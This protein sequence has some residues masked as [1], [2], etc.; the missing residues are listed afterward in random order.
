LQAAI[1][2]NARKQEQLQQEI[3]VYQS[4]VQL[5]PRIEQEFKE[6]TR[7]YDTALNF[8]RDMLKKKTD[9][10][11]AADL[12][13][14][15]QGEQF[16]V[17]DSAN[18]PEKPSFPNRPLF[19][20]GGFAGGIGLGLGIALLLELRDKV[21]R[22]ERDIEFYLGVPTLALVPSVGESQGGGSK[23]WKREQKVA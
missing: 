14:R 2:E 6:L 19:A 23:L 15:Q 5:S 10:E 8:Y 4:R 1:T 22:N 11:M 12:D 17:M 21:I 16:S 18:L 9:S 13:K 3:K 20:A 7:D